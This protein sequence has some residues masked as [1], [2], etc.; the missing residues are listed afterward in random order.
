[1]LSDFLKGFDE[2]KKK[3]DNMSEEEFMEPF[4]EMGIEFVPVEETKMISTTMLQRSIIFNVELQH[5]SAY[6]KQLIA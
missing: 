5:S 4:L 1:M 6:Q 2:F 3:Y